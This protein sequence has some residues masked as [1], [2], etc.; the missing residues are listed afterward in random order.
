T[1]VPMITDTTRT[2]VAGRNVSP[3]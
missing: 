3:R 2:T 1:T